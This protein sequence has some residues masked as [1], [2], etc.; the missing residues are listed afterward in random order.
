MTRKCRHCKAELPSLKLSNPIQRKGFCSFDD[1]AQ[2]GLNKAREQQQKK[3]KR[4][5]RKRKEK[6][7]TR[8]DY[9]KE[10]QK[11]VNNYVRKR[12]EHKVCISCGSR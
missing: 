1:A 4:E 10:A 8:S 2:Y 7:K 9:V 11:A 6:L 12:D 5:L 3:E